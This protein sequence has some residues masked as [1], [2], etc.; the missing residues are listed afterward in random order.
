MKFLRL[1]AFLLLI[2]G[3]NT[4]E[5][6]T[7]FYAK[8]I[9]IKDGD[10]I[11]VLYEKNPMKI[12]LADIDC[13]EKSQPYGNRAKQ[14]TSE[15]CFNKTVE[16]ITKAKYDRYHRLVATIII[17]ST[18]NLNKELIKA[19]LAWHYKKYSDDVEIANLESIARYEKQGLW[20]DSNSISPSEWRK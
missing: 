10:T 15:L 1:L 20:A 4:E 6:P 12:R 17:G 11:E 16:V 19:G 8:V 13:P 7:R 9:G 2:T 3:C 14:L 18:V 5:L